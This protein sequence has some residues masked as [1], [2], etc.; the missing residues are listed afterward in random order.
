MCLRQF[1]DA[2]CTIDPDQLPKLNGWDLKGPLGDAAFEQFQ[3][4]SEV[5]R[6]GHH[7]CCGSFQLGIVEP[8]IFSTLRLHGFSPQL[9][10]D[11]RDFGRIS[12]DNPNDPEPAIAREIAQVAAFVRCSE[13]HELPRS[14]D[15]KSAICEPRPVMCG[16]DEGLYPIGVASPQAIELGHLNEPCPGRPFDRDLRVGTDFKLVREP[17]LVG[18]QGADA[19]GFSEIL[20]ALQH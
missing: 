12:L 9:V 17:G 5:R 19:G 15:R 1:V 11:G 7:L 6:F 2:F 14:G 4:W 3:P 8:Q 20:R 16:R 13:E 10:A 18:A